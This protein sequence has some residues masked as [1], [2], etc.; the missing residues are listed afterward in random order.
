MEIY[1]LVFIISFLLCF[2]DFVHYKRLKMIPYTIFCLFI[3]GL[4]GFRKI[5]IDNDAESYDFMFYLYDRSTL[6]E[7][8]EGGYGYVEKGYVLLNKMVSYLGFDIHTL[9]ILIALMTGFA[10]YYYFYKKSRFPFLSLLFYVSFYF[11]YR[12]FT[13]VRYAFA[14]A[15]CFWVVDFYLSKKYKKSIL[16]FILAVLFHNAVTILIPVLLVLRFVKN[17]KW[18][19]IPILPTVIIG[20]MINLFPLLLSLGITNEHMKLY[21]DEESGGGMLVSIMGVAIMFLYY[22]VTFKKDKRDMIMD[23]YFRILSIGV[24]LNFLFIQSAIFQRFTFILFQFSILLLPY[25]LKELSGKVKMKGAFVLIYFFT[26]C[27]LLYYGLNMIDEN[28]VRPYKTFM[29]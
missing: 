20:K 22:L 27:F 4:A 12:D 29:E 17:N 7:I 24:S 13:Q 25:I 14:A 10:N 26:A 19:F 15:L 9:F 8:I 1:Y 3:I 23:S 5:G 6:S 16:L 21:K 18:Y 2:F 11:L 28:L